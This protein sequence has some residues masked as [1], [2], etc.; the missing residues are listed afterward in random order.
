MMMIRS[1]GLC[2]R[3]C[4]LARAPAFRSVDYDYFAVAAVAAAQVEHNYERAD[5]M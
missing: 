4:V 3:K 5:F 2:A 1:R